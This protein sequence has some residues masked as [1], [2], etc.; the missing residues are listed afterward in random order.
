MGRAVLSPR[1]EPRGWGG[2]APAPDCH[3]WGWTG[4]GP[5]PACGR[6]L[7][8]CW[9]A[10]L[11]DGVARADLV[12]PCRWLGWLEGTDLPS[13]GSRRRG[14]PEAVPVRGSLRHPVGAGGVLPRRLVSRF[15]P[16]KTSA[17][18]LKF[19]RRAAARPPA[20]TLGRPLFVASLARIYRWQ[21]G[22]TLPAC[23]P[24]VAR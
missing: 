19:R 4:C 9:R 10:F 14:D 6:Q 11:R 2:G 16:P 1:R 15:S 18:W 23:L 24:T 8:G 17:E 20:A 7:F 13:L 22:G 3:R 12:R 5:A 21:T